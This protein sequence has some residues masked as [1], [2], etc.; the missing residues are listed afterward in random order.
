[1]RAYLIG[2]LSSASD[3]EVQVFGALAVILTLLAL[4]IAYTWGVEAGHEQ[5]RARAPWRRL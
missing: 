2:M 3:I 4:C 5:A 1:M